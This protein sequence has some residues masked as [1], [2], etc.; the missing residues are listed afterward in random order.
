[1]KQR[2]LAR[3]HLERRLAPLREAEGLVRPAQG[4]VR[5][6]RDALGMTAAQLAVRIG[7]TQPRIAALEKAEVTGA[8]TLE[9]LRRTAE[10]LGCTF[11]YAFIPTQ[12]LDDML[13]VRAVALA[14]QQLMRT[15]HTMKLENQALEPAELK[16]E[17]ERLIREFMHGDYRR[18]WA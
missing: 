5:A 6:I 17:R 3:K 10:G 9:S 16:E 18:L 4:W 11:V 12:P 14:E 15:H 13:R 7:V 2:L 8:V 1:M